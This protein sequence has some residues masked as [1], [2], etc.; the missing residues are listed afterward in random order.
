MKI[1]GKQMDEAQRRQLI[2]EG[3]YFRAERR[4]FT[5]GDP[6][7][8]WLEAESEL[9][10]RLH[11]TGDKDLLAE[12]DERLAA[13]NVRLSAFRKKL[14]GMTPEVRGEWTHEVEKLGSLC[15]KL[16]KRL[17]ELRARDEH[18]SRKAKNQADKIWN[19]ISD[20]IDRVTS[21]TS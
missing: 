13:A 9:D 21:R 19:E 12:L 4:G 20:V 7:N 15:D 10:A 5:G 14:S 16:Q 8:D 1:A 18:T 17:E 6:V 11:K 3:A 2:A